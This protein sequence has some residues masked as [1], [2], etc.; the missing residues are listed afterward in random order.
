MVPDT[1]EWRSSTYYDFM[2]E[3]DTDN[4]AWECLRRN[5][6]YQR[7]FSK[8]VV[9]KPDTTTAETLGNRWGLRFPRPSQPHRTRTDRILDSRDRHKRPAYR[10]ITR[11]AARDAALCVG[12]PTGTAKGRR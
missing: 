1:S 11:Y 8:L 2:D 12:P 7:D 5:T 3:V 4:L 10:P 9:E 6:A